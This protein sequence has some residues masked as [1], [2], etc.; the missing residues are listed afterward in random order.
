M[1]GNGVVPKA[2]LLDLGGVLV[3]VVGRPWGLREVAE[4]VH[5]LLRRSGCPLG[6]DR[7]ERDVRAG[8]KAYQDW[9]SAEGRRARPREMVHRE[10]WDELVAADW[11]ERARTAVGERAAALSERIDVAT[12]DRPVKA[13]ATETL[14]AVTDRGIVCAI[15]SNALS[16][17]GSRRLVREQGLEPYLAL[18]VYS[19]EEGIRKPNPQIFAIAAERIG[20]RLTECWYVGDQIDRDILGGRRAGVGR[21]LLLPSGSTGTG[22]DAVAEPDAVIQ[23]PS[24]LLDLI[25]VRVAR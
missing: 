23:R 13:D 12:K 9:K 6:L 24:D 5:D 15:V 17:A 4:E 14:R 7:V 8:W 3:D 21:V 16:G 19:D 25:P 2:V 22:N 18:Q 10:F 1:R 20:I 11:P